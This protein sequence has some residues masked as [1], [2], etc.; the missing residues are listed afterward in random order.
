MASLI[1]KA[2]KMQRDGVFG[3]SDFKEIKLES[4]SEGVAPFSCNGVEVIWKDGHVIRFG[5]VEQL[6]EFLKKVA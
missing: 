2:K 5:Q 1:G 4:L 3:N 6:V